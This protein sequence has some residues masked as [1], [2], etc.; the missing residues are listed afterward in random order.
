MRNWN[1][2]VALVCF[3]K[4]ILPIVPMRNWNW[5][6]LSLLAGRL[7]YFQSY[8]WGIEIEKHFHFWLAVYLPIVPM[9]NWNYQMTNPFLSLYALPIV[10]MRNWNQNQDQ[11]FGGVYGHFQSY[12]WGIEI[13]NGVG[14]EWSDWL[15][16]VPMRNWNYQRYAKPLNH[17]F[18]PIVPMRNWNLRTKRSKDI[19]STSNR[20][21]EE[22][23]LLW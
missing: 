8:L 11:V 14:V 22:L 23:K 5:K 15:P 19:F 18:L 1:L 3:I 10:P 13:G 17:I 20:T 6:I 2:I 4:C 21:Y 7:S 16:I 12:L 9:R